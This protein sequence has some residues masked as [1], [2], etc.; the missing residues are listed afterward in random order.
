[1]LTKKECYRGDLNLS[2]TTRSGT[3]VKVDE[4]V[5]VIVPTNR[6]KQKYLVVS[7]P[8]RNMA[9]N[10]K[11]AVNELL[12]ERVMVSVTARLAMTSM[13]LSAE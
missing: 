2:Q 4:Y 3:A 10:I 9:N 8:I 1:M 12:S 5:P 6:A 7:P 11:I 13:S